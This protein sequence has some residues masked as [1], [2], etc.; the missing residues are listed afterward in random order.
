[1]P[2]TRAGFEGYRLLREYFMMPERF[3]FA[4]VDGLQPVVRRCE[5]GLEIVFLLRRPAP[6]LADL[7]PADLA[8]LRD[9]GHQPLRARLQRH[10]DRPAAAAPG[11]A[12]R[13][14]AAARLRD[15]PRHRVEDADRDGPEARYPGALRL[16][17]E[18]GRG[19]VCSAERRPR[20][21]AR[22]RA[23]RRAG[24]APPTPA[25]TSSSRCP[26]RPAPPGRPLRLAARALCTNRDLPILDDQPTLTLESGDPVRG[27]DAPRARCARRAR[28]CRRRRRGRGGESRAD[29]LAW[30]LVAQLSLNYLGLA[31]EGGAPSR[32]GRRSTSTPTAAT[33]RS[34]ATPARSRASTPA[35]SSSGCR[36]PGR[37]ASAAAP[38]SR[39]T[40]TNVLLAGTARC[41]F[42]RCSRGSSPATP[43]S[44]PSCGPAPGSCRATR[45]CHGR[46]RSATAAWSERSRPRRWP[47]TLDFFEL[48]R[49]LEVAGRLFGR[50][51]RPD[52]EPARLGQAV[53]L[54]FA[55][56]DVAA[57]PCRRAT[58]PARVTVAIFGLLGPEGP[59]PLH[60][61]RW[62]LDRL[63]QRWFAAGV[64]ARDQRHHL[65]RL[66]QHA[67]A[68]DARALLPRLGRPAPGRAGRARGGGRVRAMLGAL[69]GTAAWPRRRPGARAVKLGQAAAL[70]HQVLGPE[71]LTGSSRD[72]FGVPVQLQEFVGT[73]SAIPAPL[74][75][76]L[77]R[78][79]P[80]S[81][82]AR[83]SGRASSS[84]RADR[85]SHRAAG[86]CGLQVLPA[87]RRAARACC[88]RSA[89]SARRSTSTCGPCSRATRS[90][91]P[92]SAPRS[93]AAPPGLRPPR[94][95]RRRG[96]APSASSAW[97][98]ERREGGGMSLLLTLVQGPRPQQCGRCGSTRASW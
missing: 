91:R 77:G 71:R 7:S 80:R 26:G 30:R 56:R 76:R 79:T 25:T 60:L 94:K 29:E 10:R 70:G 12:R 88:T 46:S 62:V 64:E 20:R 55:A 38:R 1:M 92:G 41:C 83:R 27:G 14:H 82:A 3:H 50:A 52:R 6:E 73:W 96:S 17:P 34:P 16:R 47:T 5:A 98:H 39:S 22:G 43:R 67:A 63:S 19:W 81:A 87:R 2:R 58:A 54:G 95:G 37:C 21:P 97:R 86:L 90:P 74:Q 18:P 42:R 4:R 48:L 65:P 36:S 85:A 8:A 53:R 23:A 84:A 33:R 40:S 45:R 44:T 31:V 9:A 13:P 15:L 61:T 78:R 68:P 49:R 57:V 35:R 28:A 89:R 11:A 75:S 51:G 32:S 69:A 93:S 24:R 66:R 72:A 59:L